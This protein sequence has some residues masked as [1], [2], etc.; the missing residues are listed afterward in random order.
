MLIYKR[1]KMAQNVTFTFNNCTFNGT[2][3][4]EL[5][6]HQTQPNTATLEKQLE[7]IRE[8]QVFLCKE[9][10]E[11]QKK[12][13]T[14]VTTPAP[15]TDCEVE[16]EVAGGDEQVC[17]STFN[18]KLQDISDRRSRLMKSSATKEQKEQELADLT[19]EKA[20]LIEEECADR[21]KLVW[22]DLLDQELVQ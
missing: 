5:V 9:M 11:L 20:V 2:G 1:Y 13:A 17:S 3:L 22:N 21:V 8:C 18:E 6:R 19:D 7:L 14:Q 4:Q 12:M 10:D 16:E 15:E